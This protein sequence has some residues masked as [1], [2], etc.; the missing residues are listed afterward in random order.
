[1]IQHTVAKTTD[2]SIPIVCDFATDLISPPMA[3]EKAAPINGR[4]GQ[5]ETRMVCQTSKP[6]SPHP[7]SF[8]LAIIAL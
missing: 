7:F 6:A 2:P 8:P 4:N 5:L 1:M 3:M